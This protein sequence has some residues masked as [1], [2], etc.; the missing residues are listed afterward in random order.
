MPRYRML[1]EYD[2]TDFH[3]WQ[4][5]P[6]VPTIQGTLEEAVDTITSVQSRV[7]GSGRTD[8]G[9]HARGQVAHVDLPNPRD[10]FR[11]RG[12]LNGVTPDSIAVRKVEKA[13]EDFHSRY[14]ARRR[15]YHY[16]LATQ[17]CALGRQMRT[18]V[19][20]PPHVR[21]MRA[22]TPDLLG[23]HHF[24]SFCRTQSSTQNRVCTITH[25]QWKKGDRRGFWR[26]E[27]IGTRFLHGMVRAI[28]GTII[29]IGH[30]KRS[31]DVLPT[32]MAARDRRVAGPSAAAEGLV[33]ESVHYPERVLG[34]ASAPS[35]RRPRN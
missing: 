23:R 26:F 24:G 2:G 15:R 8:A 20:P 18:H 21:R 13:P 32:V 29:E 27:I 6:D 22:A 10:P 33:L 31:A 1:I 16:Y 25:A 12:S 3:G 35:S 11:L 7:T 4:I 17:P 30:G 19:R 9:V 28:V 34:V 14:D 5:Q